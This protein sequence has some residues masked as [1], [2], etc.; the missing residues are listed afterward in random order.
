MQIV[1]VGDICLWNI[2]A[3]FLGEMREIFKKSRL[4]KVLPSMQSVSR[5]IVKSE[6]RIV[7]WMK[8]PHVCLLLDSTLLS[9]QILCALNCVYGHRGG[10]CVDEGAR[11]CFQV[12]LRVAH[13]KTRAF[14]FTR[15]VVYMLKL[16]IENVKKQT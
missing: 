4:L 8:A 12:G 3:C 1:S 2:K 10:W 7:K 14:H 6:Y 5:C 15:E 11:F 9:G 13:I 16:I